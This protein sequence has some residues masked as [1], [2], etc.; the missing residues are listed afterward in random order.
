[1]LKAGQTIL[2]PKPGQDTLHLWVIVLASDPVTHE[3]VIVNLTT[4]R[5]QSDGTVV[6]QPG[7][8]PFVQHATVVFY[9]DARISDAKLIAAAIE[10]G[11]FR[12]HDDCSPELLFRIQQGLFASP[13][14]PK[15]VKSFAA[16]RLKYIPPL[17]S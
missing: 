3:I 10:A 11:T 15:K 2:L 16:T 5:H 1:M 12:T 4:Q 6:L 9:A 7:A 14:T 17:S 13:H 8:H